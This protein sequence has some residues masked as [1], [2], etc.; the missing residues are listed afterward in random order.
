M[1]VVDRRIILFVTR[2]KTV[3]NPGVHVGTAPTQC[4]DGAIAVV[5]VIQVLASFDNAEFTGEKAI[6]IAHEIRGYETTVNL[7]G[8][9][10]KGVGL[11]I[12]HVGTWPPIRCNIVS[13]A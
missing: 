6:L 11:G 4:T 5:V 3:V 7:I 12:E 8:L 1:Y 2:H 13:Y 9:S 10:N